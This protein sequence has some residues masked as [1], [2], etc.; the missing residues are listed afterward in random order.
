MTLFQAVCKILLCEKPCPV[1]ILSRKA[2][3]DKIYLRLKC[4][5]NSIRSYCFAKYFPFTILDS[6]VLAIYTFYSIVALSCF[7]NPGNHT[8][9]NAGD[10]NGINFTLASCHYFHRYLI[11]NWFLYF[12][13]IIEISAKTEMFYLM[14]LLKASREKSPFCFDSS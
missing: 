7:Y 2:T 11:D 10:Y 4:T 9:N 1:K 14:K 5:V 12:L 8:I 13:T 6:V 3:P